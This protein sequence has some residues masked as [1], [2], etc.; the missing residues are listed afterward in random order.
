VTIVL[1]VVFGVLAI[2]V[3]SFYAKK[4]L[5]KILEEQNEENSST[6]REGDA[7]GDGGDVEAGRAEEVKD[8]EQQRSGSQFT[9][10]AGSSS[11]SSST[12]DN[13]VP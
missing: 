13:H 5:N 11:L 4:E 7:N 2:F 9:V 1:G 6:G 8:G 10:A 12:A 3:V